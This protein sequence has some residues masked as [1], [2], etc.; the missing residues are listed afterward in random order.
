VRTVFWESATRDARTS[1]RAGQRGCQ[2]AVTKDTD[3]ITVAATAANV[4]LLAVFAHPDD[5]SFR[6][7]R[8]LALLARAA[9]RP[10]VVPT[11]CPPCASVSCAVPASHWA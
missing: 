3:I 2:C 1:I 7:G 4:M 5:E 11:N 10:C 6:C 8:T 9:T